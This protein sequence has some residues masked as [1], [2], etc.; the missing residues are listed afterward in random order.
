MS[1]GLSWTLNSTETFRIVQKF[2]VSAWGK[3]GFRHEKL[4]SASP[5][6][7]STHARSTRTL[8]LF[9]CEMCFSRHEAWIGYKYD[10]M[11]G[12]WKWSDGT[13]KD[14]RYIWRQ[15]KENVGPET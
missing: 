4:K 8:G 11:Y 6:G 12:G 3:Q 9:E 7:V 14:Y 15:K 2:L 10:V 5:P 13:C 1:P